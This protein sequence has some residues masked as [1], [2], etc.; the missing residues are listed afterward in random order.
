MKS[1][2][3]RVNLSLSPLDFPPI[4]GLGQSSVSYQTATPYISN[5][6]V[7]LTI[8]KKYILLDMTTKK[9]HEVIS[10]QSIYEIPSNEI[11]NREDVYEF[12]KDA[13][14]GLNEAYQYAQTLLPTLPTILFP[15]QPIENYQGEI[16]RVFNLLNSQN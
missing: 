16:D 12:Y 7:V 13:T 10:V 2:N 1:R 11:K 9:E 14:L 4:M 5:N 3:Y 15:T 8:T 6:K